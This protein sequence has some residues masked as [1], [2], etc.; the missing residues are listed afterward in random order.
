MGRN[1]RRSNTNFHIYPHTEK[2][3]YAWTLFNPEPTG[4]QKSRPQLR[5]YAD[6]VLKILD[7]I[8]GDIF[9]ILH[10]FIIG[11]DNRPILRAHFDV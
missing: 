6:K 5:Y 3:L 1:Y 11:P 7:G 9:I 10:L 2:L 8:L 4:R